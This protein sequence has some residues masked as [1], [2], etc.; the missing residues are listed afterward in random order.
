MFSNEGYAELS[1]GISQMSLLIIFAAAV[2]CTL[3][4]RL[5]EIF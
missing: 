3:M 1:T 5:F 2:I 4:A